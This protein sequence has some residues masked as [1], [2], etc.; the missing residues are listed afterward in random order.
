MKKYLLLYPPLGDFSAPYLSLPVL[1]GQLRGEGFNVKTI[2]LNIAFYEKVLTQKYLSNSVYKLESVYNKLKNFF[3]IIENINSNENIDL[4]QKYQEI[5]FFIETESIPLQKIPMIV[6]KAV[7]IL[8]NPETFY[9]YKLML[10]ATN[11]ILISLYTASL[12]YTPY[13][14]TWKT[15]DYMKYYKV[16]KEIVFNKKKN[17]YYE[18]YQN[19]AEDI[20]ANKYDYIGISCSS[21]AQLIPTLTIANQLKTE[22]NAH[23]NIGGNVFTE[24]YEDLP[25]HPDFFDLFAHTVSFG[26]GEKTIVELAKY[27][28]NRNTIN[29][30]PNICYKSNN[31]VIRNKVEKTT[32]ISNFYKPDFSD[33]DFS[34]YITPAVILPVRISIGCYW[35]KCTFC[36]FAF[37]SNYS[38]KKIT[39]FVDELV[40]YKEDYKI[41]NF[42]FVDESVPPLFLEKLS[43]ELIKREINIKFSMFARL[44]EEFT[45]KLL[46]KAYIAGLRQ[47]R[48]GVETVNKRINKIMKK[49]IEVKHIKR[50][51]K[52]AKKA[53]IANTTCFI[54]G[55]PTAT[56]KEDMETINFIFKNHRNDLIFNTHLQQF[57][58]RKGSY[59][60]RHPEEFNIEIINNDTGFS[61][62]L[63]FKYKNIN[64][65]NLEKITKQYEIFTNKHLSKYIKHHTFTNNVFLYLCKY[66]EK[67]V[68]KMTI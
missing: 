13:K 20:Q 61:P 39:A 51:L 54:Y 27:I 44:E 42:I 41:E 35:R 10:K 21:Y 50:I 62:F 8:K 2:D 15:E 60:S 55:F 49:G 30:I 48:W 63:D 65:N 6:E 47:I 59:I 29:N 37:A 17:P 9:N 67:E 52:S 22:T 25:K 12:V 23:I 26:A 36:N 19:I 31:V 18:I 3:E 32:N 11:I 5:K 28:D 64:D 56:Y 7:G 4:Y 57:S 66:G 53:G 33:Y 14:F 46:K 24:I 38:I 45:F 58:V 68:N 1:A 16:L 40:K 34:Q 43:E